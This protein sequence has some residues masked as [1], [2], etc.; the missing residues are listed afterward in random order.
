MALIIPVSLFSGLITFTF[1]MFIYYDLYLLFVFLAFVLV[2]LVAYI[3]NYLYLE[4]I[5]KK[6][7]EGIGK[8][9]L[10]NLVIYG[11]TLLYVFIILFVGGY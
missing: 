2:I 5:T 7:I 4:S 1:N 8:V 9:C 10:N 11:L 3:T 6:Q